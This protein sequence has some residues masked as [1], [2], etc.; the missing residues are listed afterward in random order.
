[1]AGLNLTR[2]NHMDMADVE[3]LR[4][5]GGT[6]GDFAADILEFSVKNSDFTSICDACAVAWWVD[7]RVI[8]NS[9]RTQVDVETKGEFTRGMTVCDWRDFMGTDPEQEISREK[10]WNKYKTS[11]NVEVAMEFDQKR[12]REVLFDT[13]RSYKEMN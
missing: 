11:G 9:I 12:F 5:I 6:V 8:T 4:A 7:D 2:Q 13:V 3:Q 1:M 10:C